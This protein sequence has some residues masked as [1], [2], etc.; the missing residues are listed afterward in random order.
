M[1]LRDELLLE[2]LEPV[3]RLVGEPFDLRERPADGEH[4]AAHA[5]ADGLA[6]AFRQLTLELGGGGRE[7]LDLGAGA[8]ERGFES[9][10]LEPPLAGLRDARAS[11]FQGLIVHGRQGYSGRRMRSAELDYDLPPELIAQH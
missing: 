4:L 1:A 9:R 8:V 5:L 2:P 6:D 3:V 10:R 7:R 11:P